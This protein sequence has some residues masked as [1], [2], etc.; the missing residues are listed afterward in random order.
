MSRFWKSRQPILDGR[1]TSSGEL[2]STAGRAPWHQS[3]SSPPMSQRRACDGVGQRRS[4]R[5]HPGSRTGD[6]A[7]FSRR[8]V[9][10]TYAASG[11]D[12]LVEA[13]CVGSSRSECGESFSQRGIAQK[14]F[15]R[16]TGTAQI[17]GSTWSTPSSPS[18]WVPG[19]SVSQRDHLSGDCEQAA[20]VNGDVLSAHD[21]AAQ[22]RQP[23]IQRLQ[24]RCTRAPSSQATSPGSGPFSWGAAGSR[25]SWR[26]TGAMS[27]RINAG[28][29]LFAR[30]AL[31]T[32]PAHEVA[33]V[34]RDTFPA[35]MSSGAPVLGTTRSAAV[36]P[37]GGME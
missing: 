19:V 36:V 27:T 31:A 17:L 20:I 21:L 26:S 13:R 37:V 24:R 2:T 29:Y 6:A 16:P 33:S 11:G 10:T 5:D 14:S 22:T 18:R 30:E 23:V 32:I 12:P 4:R 34:D 28:C 15:A 25:R 1:T 35:L 3:L 9:P 7:R 8:H